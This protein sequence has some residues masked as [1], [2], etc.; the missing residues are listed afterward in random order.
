MVYGST[1]IKLVGQNFQLNIT[2]VNLIETGLQ[3]TIYEFFDR[4]DIFLK[5]Q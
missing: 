1:I 4:G 5:L 3:T 2:L